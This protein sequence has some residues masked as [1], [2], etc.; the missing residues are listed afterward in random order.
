MQPVDGRQA[1]AR[2]ARPIAP[3]DAQ[4]IEQFLHEL[5]ETSN[6]AA[7]AA[8]AGLPVNRIYRLRRTDPDFARQ[9]YAALAE[10]YDNLEMELLH[11][12]RSGETP[13]D[14]TPPRKFDTAIALR[15]LTAHRESVA[16]EKGRRTLADEVATIASINAK[17]DDMR[18]RSKAGDAAVRKARRDAA[19]ARGNG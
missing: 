1:K 10:G 2:T 5:A 11:H 19:K 18:A 6:V 15:C 12:L 17:I 3:R 8:V 14:G 7:A 9:W 16:R 13:G 4:R